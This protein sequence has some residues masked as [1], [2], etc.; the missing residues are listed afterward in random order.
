[1]GGGGW[2][3]TLHRLINLFIIYQK[4]KKKEIFFFILILEM[5]GGKERDFFNLFLSQIMWFSF[6]F[7]D[8]MGAINPKELQKILWFS[9]GDVIEFKFHNK[10][11][12]WKL[13]SGSWVKNKIGCRITK[14]A[15][16]ME[17]NT[18]ANLLLNRIAEKKEKIIK[19]KWKETLTRNFLKKKR[20]RKN[21]L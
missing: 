15:E 7:K 5:C 3:Q 16:K 8:G 13:I 11:F 6:S 10:T 4:K 14:K 12:I 2:K 21:D 1:M 17:W 18:M 9:V 19:T 20:K